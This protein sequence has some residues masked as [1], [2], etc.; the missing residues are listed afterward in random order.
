MP[1]IEAL[2]LTASSSIYAVPLY[3]YTGIPNR[4]TDVI[5][6]CNY[7]SQCITDTYDDYNSCLAQT[8]QL[9]WC[10]QKELEADKANID[11]PQCAIGLAARRA[12]AANRDAAKQF[13][14][15]LY[16]CPPTSKCVPDLRFNRGLCCPD[17]R[18][19]ACGGR[20][21]SACVLPHFRDI[22]SCECICPPLSCPEGLVQDPNTCECACPPQVCS[23]GMRLNPQTC[24]CECPPPLN[25]CNGLC[26][27]TSTDPNNCGTCGTICDVPDE[28]CCNGHCVSLNTPEN[29]GACGI[30]VPSGSKCCDRVPTQLGTCANCGECGEKC[31]APGSKKEGCCQG[32][33]TDL[34]TDQNCGACGRAVAPGQKCC[35]RLVTQLG[36]VTDCQDCG[37]QCAIGASCTGL[38][39]LP[40]SCQCPQ[41]Q[42]P[43]GTPP[44][45]CRDNMTL[46]PGSGWL[47][48]RAANPGVPWFTCPYGVAVCNP[49]LITVASGGSCCPPGFPVLIGDNCCPAGSLVISNGMCIST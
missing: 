8:P 14:Q 37:N 17:D 21:W 35:Q 44:G 45:R 3:R 43:C 46:P 1:G 6:D 20:C 15:I 38:G 16:A 33:L 36:T 47:A 19:D 49:T 23:G 13:C 30:Q 4:P 10:S 22:W 39:P 7:L 25:D 12:C 26:I 9:N 31:G 29:C 18:S 11:N 5:G 27:D 32:V 34:N 48:W 42:I 2:R 41:D 40:K 24:M 28:G